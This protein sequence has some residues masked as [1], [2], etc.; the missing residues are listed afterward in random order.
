LAL[1]LTFV[2]GI[3][4]AVTVGTSYGAYLE[5]ENWQR[6]KAASV[7]SSTHETLV[8]DYDGRV[9]V[10]LRD[11]RG[12][13]VRYL[14]ANRMPISLNNENARWLMGSHLFRSL[15]TWSPWNGR[16]EYP[17]EPL[18]QAVKSERWFFV[19]DRQAGRAV[20][21]GYDAVTHRLL[22]FIGPD[23]FEAG[24]RDQSKG[25]PVN[26]PVNGPIPWGTNQILWTH[27]T[28]DYRDQEYGLAGVH[29]DSHEPLRAGQWV[30]R[31]DE[32][33]FLV[34]LAVRSVTD[35]LPGMHV[36]SVAQASRVV[37]TDPDRAPAAAGV[38]RQVEYQKWLAIRTADRVVLIN[39]NA[40]LREEYVLPREW[41]ERD[42]EIHFPSDGTAVLKSHF[43]PRVFHDL[44][45]GIREYETDVV[46][47][48]RTGEVSRQARFSLQYSFNP[49]WAPG[50]RI[51]YCLTTLAI[52]GPLPSALVAGV[53]LP[54]LDSRVFQ[55]QFSD[56]VVVS[57]GH[58]WPVLAFVTL[59]AA[60]LTWLA[61]R[62]LRAYR[63]PRSYGW[64]AFVFLL[65]LPGYVAWYCHRRWPI[66]H[67][68]PPPQKTGTEIFA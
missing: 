18:N 63:E 51:V 26:G 14:D 62:H 65:G 9:V 19:C 40:G 30:L 32:Q 21:E 41:N 5:F 11:S 23:G 37:R 16:R 34:D 67:P 28:S 6:K 66:R 10:A 35:L 49:N 29:F 36:L 53:V 1:T 57:L 42:F 33:L 39:P 24:P 15:R 50:E 8:V 59:M 44:S 31:S 4:C 43:T 27:E 47:I 61:D 38:E 68:V 22:G 64:L 20:F 55:K 56:R 3:F 17:I 12:N 54:Q 52:P 58:A 48:S 46:T 7:A 45:P 13:S 60:G 2:P 25:F